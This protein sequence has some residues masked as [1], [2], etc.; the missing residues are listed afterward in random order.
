MKVVYKGQIEKVE[1]GCIPCGARRKGKS[2]FVTAK[3]F[4]VPS[5]RYITFHIDQ[6]VEVSERDGNFL[7]EY[8]YEDING[9]RR[10]IFEEVQ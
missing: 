4:H 2:R 9:L 10:P 7:L 6:V 1:T 8:N 5:G 3:S